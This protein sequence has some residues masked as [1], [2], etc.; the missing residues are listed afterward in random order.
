VIATTSA[1]RRMRDVVATTLRCNRPELG[2]SGLR[3]R[4]SVEHD[5]DFSMPLQRRTHEGRLAASL[6]LLLGRCSGP[7]PSTVVDSFN[8]G[9]HTA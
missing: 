9:A 6:A 2:K 3:K 1:N 4:T 8:L 5:L 7:S